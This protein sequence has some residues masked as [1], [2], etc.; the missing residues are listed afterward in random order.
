MAS[1]TVQYLGT[2]RR[3][4]AVARVFLRPGKGDITINGRA[5]DHY[6][7][8]EAARTSVRQALL[9]TETADKFDAAHPGLWRRNHRTGWSSPPGYRA[10]AGGIQ[11]RVAAPVEET[12]IPHPR[13]AQT[14]AQEVRTKGRP[15]AIPILQA[16]NST[17]LSHHSP[18]A[19]FRFGPRRGDWRK[20][21]GHNYHG[22]ACVV[23]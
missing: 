2:G 23:P 5:L 7:P 22:A 13:P 18:R 14:R 16:L 15:Q 6:F 4:R 8:N 10:C 21:Y 19:K 20:H 12:G 9:A 1:M 17:W 3:K 11:C